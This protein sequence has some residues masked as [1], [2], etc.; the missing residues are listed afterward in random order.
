LG[1][2]AVNLPETVVLDQPLPTGLV[3]GDFVVLEGTYGG[4]GPSKVTVRGRFGKTKVAASFRAAKRAPRPAAI[5]AAITETDRA[6]AVSEGLTLPNWYTPSMRRITGMNIAQAGRVGWQ[7]T[8]QLDAAIIERQ[9]RTRVLP[10]ARACYT[11]ALTR[12]QVLAG[13]VQLQLEV[14]KGE[15]MFAQLGTAELNHPDDR[16]LACLESAAWAM[17]VPAGNLDSQ[18]DVIHYPL[19]FTAPA[20]GQPPHTG[21]SADPMFERLL[22]SAEVLAD[23][24]NHE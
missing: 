2:L 3:A 21:E 10:R 18:V 24:Q 6:R 17:D 22:E 7:A 15:V 13:H 4:R 11:Q 12:N 8:G 23:Y 16:L 5:A 1:D 9:L 20:G 19:E 14:G